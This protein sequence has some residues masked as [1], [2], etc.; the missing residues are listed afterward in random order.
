MGRRISTDTDGGDGPVVG[1]RGREDAILWARAL[2]AKGIH[3]VR[4]RS[5]KAAPRRPALTTETRR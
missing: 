5:S 1:K 3:V 4:L 2:V